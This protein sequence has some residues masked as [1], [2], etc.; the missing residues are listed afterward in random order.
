MVFEHTLDPMLKISS[1]HYCL[2]QFD[3]STHEG[4]MFE[5]FMSDP[6]NEYRAYVISGQEVP[7]ENWVVRDGGRMVTV[8]DP[9]GITLGGEYEGMIVSV[10]T[11]L[12]FGDYNIETV[13]SQSSFA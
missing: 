2:L 7:P 8:T 9:E 10:D 5:S 11:V 6:H 1:V 4:V 13:A 12:V 3:P